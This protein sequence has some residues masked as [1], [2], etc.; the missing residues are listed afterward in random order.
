MGTFQGLFRVLSLP[1]QKDPH[2]IQVNQ[3]RRPHVPHEMGLDTTAGEKIGKY[4][5]SENIKMIFT[6][7]K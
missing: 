5:L 1:A 4:C 2:M 3:F 6:D 7:F